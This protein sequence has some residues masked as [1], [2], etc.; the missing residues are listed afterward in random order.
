MGLER[1]FEW[2]VDMLEKAVCP[3]GIL[4]ILQ[5]LFWSHFASQVLFVECQAL[6]VPSRSLHFGDP[7]RHWVR[8]WAHQRYP[9]I[10]CLTSASRWMSPS[11]S[12]HPSQN[13]GVGM[14]LP[15]F[16][17]PSQ[18]QQSLY[19]LSSSWCHFLL[20]LTAIFFFPS[21]VCLDYYK[22][23]Q[24]LLP[25]VLPPPAHSLYCRQYI[26]FKMQILIC[27]LPSKWKPL[28]LP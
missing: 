5:K 9:H 21:L 10:T 14:N 3:L 17:P 12:L 7:W 23:L 1:D 4:Q 13:P 18:G 26:L 15:L 11:L 19:I 2:K 16:F 22:R 20:M 24:F 8:S 28:L 27:S 25:S 6:P